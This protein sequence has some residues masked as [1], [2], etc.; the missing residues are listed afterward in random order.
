MSDMLLWFSVVLVLFVIGDL[1]VSK[2][3][4]KVLVVFVILF[5]FLILF[6][7]KVILVDIIEKVGMIVV[8]SWSVLMIMFSMGIMLNV[9]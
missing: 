2:I 8:V 3:K 6:V 4:V 7:I 5:L 1:I 9:K